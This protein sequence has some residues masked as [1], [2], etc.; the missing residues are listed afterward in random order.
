MILRG[1]LFFDTPVFE[2]KSFIL[3]QFADSPQRV[4]FSKCSKRVDFEGTVNDV[5]GNN[6]QKLC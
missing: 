2:Q 3:I 6:I 4:Q 1:I 5:Q